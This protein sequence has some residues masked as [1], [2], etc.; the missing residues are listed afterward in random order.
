MEWRKGKQQIANTLANNVGLLMTPT[1]LPDHNNLRA[2]SVRC[3]LKNFFFLFEWLS[4]KGRI[5]L[6]EADGKTFLTA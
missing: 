2:V 3:R 6:K 5:W 4:A 1:A